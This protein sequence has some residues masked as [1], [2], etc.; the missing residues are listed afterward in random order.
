[1]N[2]SIHSSEYKCLLQWIQRQRVE[3]D[4]SA[5]GLSAL[6]NAPHSWVSK[7]ESGER[8]LDVLEFIAICHALKVNPCDGINH[9]KEL[10]G[11]TNSS[12]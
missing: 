1:M 12:H 10:I 9:V 4:L 11:L 5:R 8:R 7:I 6:L 3:K 2:K